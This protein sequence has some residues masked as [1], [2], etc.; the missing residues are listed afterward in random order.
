M[1]YPKVRV[2]IKVTDR[3]VD[4][5]GEGLDVAIGIGQLDDSSLMARKIGEA[6]VWSAPAGSLKVCRTIQS[7]Q[8]RRRFI[9]FILP[10]LY[11]TKSSH[12]YRFFE[13]AVLARLHLI[14]IAL[15]SASV[16]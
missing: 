11:A 13:R 15:S 8:T 10:A 1:Q 4:I 9:P 12:F 3:P 6:A 2:V 14:A 5:V 16:N 7:I